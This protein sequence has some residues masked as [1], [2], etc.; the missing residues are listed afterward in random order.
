MGTF[1]QDSFTDSDTTNLSS[2]TGETG[3]TWAKLTGYSG[4]LYINGNVLE[5]EDG[6]DAEAVYY[7]SGSPAGTDYDVEAKYTWV[8]SQLC[9]WRICG[10][11]DTSNGNYYSFYYRRGSNTYRLTKRVSGTT[12]TLASASGSSPSSGTWLTLRLNLNGDALEGFEGASSVLSTTD[13]SITAAGKVGVAATSTGIS[14]P[15]IKWDD[16]SATEA[17]GDVSL[18]P[19]D[20]G[21]GH[22]AGNVTL[23]QTHA[24]SISAAAHTHAA[25]NIALSV[26]GALDIANGAHVHAADNLTLAQNSEIVIANGLHSHAAD[27]VPLSQVHLLSVLPALHAHAASLAVLAAE[28]VLA[29]PPRRLQPEARSAVTADASTRTMTAAKRNRS[30]T[31]ER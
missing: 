8:T 18:T 28:G 19:A 5:N 16:F 13:S 3:A 7:A 2:H 27:V 12:T 9:D 22:S 23:G 14:G 24:L 20:A 6:S 25:Q 4:N 10:R 31:P 29:P 21:H 15:R 26:S 17:D 30:L 1:V 11:I